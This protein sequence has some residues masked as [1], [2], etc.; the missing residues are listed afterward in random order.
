MI[1]RNWAGN[2]AYRYARYVAPAS[3]EELRAAVVGARRVRVVATRHSF[4]D[5]CDT[6]DLLVDVS[7]LATP[8]R[9]DARRGVVTV[10]AGTRS[11]DV[12]AAVQAEGWALPNMGSLPHIS[13]IGAISTGTHGSGLGNQVLGASVTRARVLLADGSEVE[14][15]RRQPELSGVI[16]S[17]GALGVVTEVDV[18]LRP[19]FD[20]VQTVDLT[21]TWAEVRPR[22]PDLLGSAYSV[23][24]F[25]RWHEEEIAEVLAKTE[26]RPGDPITPSPSAPGSSSV[27]GDGENLT[28]R[29]RVVPWLEALPHFR[30]DRE[31]SFGAEIQSEFFV[32]FEA[33]REALEVIDALAERIRPHLIVSE[34]RAVAADDLWLSPASG[35]DTTCVHFTWHPHPREVEGLT[36][37]IQQ[38]L[39]PLGGRPHWGKVFDPAL[40]DAATAYPR[41][42]EFA[43]LAARLDPDGTFANR[44]VER[45]L[46]LGSRRDGE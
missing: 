35:R 34:L 32:P 28:V 30:F 45:A 25:T 17:L 38:R 23:S 8:P 2:H 19:T 13:L 5:A 6:D 43:A 20:L 12:A 14:F 37:E 18:A 41:S 4:N 27:L 24:V 10:T 36:R 11:G 26:A 1:E 42:G 46:G 33:T 15:T 44:F 22:V 3:V 31:P 7:G 9:V 21:G 16:T 29:D 39:L 40:V